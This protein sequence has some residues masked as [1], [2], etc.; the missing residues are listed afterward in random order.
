MSGKQVVKDDKGKRKI[1]DYTPG[2]ATLPVTPGSVVKGASMLVGYKYGALEIGEKLQDECIKIKDTP[3]KCSWKPLGNINDIDAYLKE[4]D[5]DV[6]DLQSLI[7]NIDD[8]VFKTDKLTELED[9]LGKLMLGEKL[10]AKNNEGELVYKIA[11]GLYDKNYKKIDSF[12]LETIY[13]FKYPCIKKALIYITK[14]N[15]VIKTAI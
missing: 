4:I 3:E 6:L 13:F 8:K 1:I 5:S 10:I 14:E 15:T 11:P 9:M 12:I 2:I 7:R